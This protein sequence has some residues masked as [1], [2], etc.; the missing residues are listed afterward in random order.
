VPHKQEICK[1][2]TMGGKLIRHLH[3]PA[4]SHSLQYLFV[5]LRSNVL[6]LTGMRH[7]RNVF[8]FVLPLLFC[9]GGLTATELIRMSVA[10]LSTFGPL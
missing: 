8:F 10:N 6:S 5:G 7:L 9:E 2:M 3:G 4:L 1:D